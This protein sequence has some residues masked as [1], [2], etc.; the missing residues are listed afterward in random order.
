[1]GSLTAATTL[2]VNIT[3]VGSA[4]TRAAEVASPTLVDTAAFDTFANVTG[5]LDGLDVDTGA[6]LSYKIDGQ[7]PDLAGDTVLAG[8]Y[9]TLTVHADGSYSYDPSDAANN[10]LSAPTTDVFNVQVSDGSLTAATTL[11]VNIT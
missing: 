8:S 1:D 6:S 2:T 3:G 9:G 4:P 11:T 10:T 5:Q 7:A